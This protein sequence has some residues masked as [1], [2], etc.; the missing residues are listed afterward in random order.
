MDVTGYLD[1]LQRQGRALAAAA[2]AAGVDAPVP[3]CPGWTVRD[4][5]AHTGGVHAWAVPFVRADPAADPDVAE[6]DLAR[7]EGDP[8]AW[9]R[10]RN[11]ELVAALRAA[12]PDLP[13]GAFLP[14][15]SPL[16]FWARRQAHEAAV[17]RADADAAAGTP[18]PAAGH[19][20]EFA[21][22]GIDELLMGFL[23][24]PGR[25]RSDAAYRFVVAPDDAPA[26]WLVE[27]GPDGATIERGTGPADATL[28]GSA[29][30]LYLHL[31][32]R[33]PAVP[34]EGDAAVAARWREL[35]RVTWE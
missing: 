32:N 4:L 24:R 15:P 7:P 9:Y 3:T 25:L 27:V 28:R 1:E 23:S 18:D 5:L 20:T 6:D 26:R 19:P 8:L 34:V 11:A 33:V 29:G 10:E 21:V 12:P 35:A 16:A 17:H 30:L 31:W 14:A 2:A 13:T 22:D